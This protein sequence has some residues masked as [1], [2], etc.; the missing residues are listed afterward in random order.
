[1]EK[2]YSE[3]DVVNA[4]D[5]MRKFLIQN[6]STEWLIIKEHN[7]TL[8]FFGLHNK[9]D[10]KD[11]LERRVS[12]QIQDFIDASERGLTNMDL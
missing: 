5:V 12:G 9:N 3:Q 8:M 4:L 1:M 2:T 6:S 10:A 7:N 11:N